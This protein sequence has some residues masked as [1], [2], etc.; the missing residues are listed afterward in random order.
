V[1]AARSKPDTSVSSISSVP[2]SAGA[3][4]AADECEEAAIVV[5]FMAPT[6]LDARHSYKQF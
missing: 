2:S 3:E 6:S 5:K 1:A 4:T